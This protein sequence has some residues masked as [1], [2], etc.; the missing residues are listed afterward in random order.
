MFRPLLPPLLEL[1]FPARCVGCGRRGVPLCRPCRDSLPYLPAAACRRCASPLAVP[2]RCRSCRSVAGELA[3]IRAVCAYEGTA[4]RAV[5]TLKFRSGRY[6]AP[7][8]GGLMA[9]VARRRPLSADLVV[10]V[11][12]AAG[13]L[14]RRGYNQ[15]EL[16]AVVAAP[17][18][19]GVLASDVLTRDARRP[20]QTLDAAGR[21]TNLKG[22]IH[23]PDPDRVAGRRVVLVD[24]VVTTGATLSACAEQLAAAGAAHVGAL[25]FA[26]D[27]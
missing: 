13:R 15:A 18:T 5:H 2:G 20:Q 1:I 12:L 7:V 3:S 22:A 16:L 10:P 24:D 27:V 17:A 9:E 4:R 19:G 25:V 8:L 26:R 6:L 11:P 21:R 23:C 14:R